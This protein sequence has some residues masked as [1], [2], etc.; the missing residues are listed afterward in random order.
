MRMRSTVQCNA[1]H[2]VPCVTARPT[3]PSRSSTATANGA[4]MM[5]EEVR[6]GKRC[7]V[8]TKWGKKRGRC[9]A[10]GNCKRHYR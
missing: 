7:K 10:D 6:E 1:W 8:H 2:G 5:Q 3:A 4:W 9:D